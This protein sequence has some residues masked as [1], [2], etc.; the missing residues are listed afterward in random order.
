VLLALATGVC[1][2][3]LRAKGTAA[4]LPMTIARHSA[5]LGE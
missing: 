2:D 5:L 1:V 3:A 4:R